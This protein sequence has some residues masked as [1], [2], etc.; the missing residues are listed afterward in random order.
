MATRHRYMTSEELALHPLPDKRTELVRG[1]LIIREP[2]RRRHGVVAAR[3]LIAIG[4]YLETYPIGEVMAAETG[5]TLTRN[6]DTVRA[7]DVAYLRADRVPT[8]EVIGF[9]EIAPDLAVEVLSPSDRAKQMQAKIDD[10][11][12]AG[13]LLV[14][15]IDPRRRVARVHR[16]DGTVSVLTEHDLLIGEDVLPAF[17]LSLARVLAR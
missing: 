7:P 16:A 8:V 12:A 3:I 5:F 15:V 6:P 9:D 2:A 17:T 11:I 4:I 14:W 13:T 1:R 10:W